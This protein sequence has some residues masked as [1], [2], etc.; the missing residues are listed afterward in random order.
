MKIKCQSQRTKITFGYL[1]YELLV[2][3]ILISLKWSK[4]IVQ[5]KVNFIQYITL[6]LKKFIFG[7]GLYYVGKKKRWQQQKRDCKHDRDKDHDKKDDAKKIV[8]DNDKKDDCKKDGGKKQ[9][10]VKGKALVRGLEKEKGNKFFH[11]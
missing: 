2:K 7:R 5:V 9:V 8:K 10:R 6:T 1:F 3:L 11:V 4:Y